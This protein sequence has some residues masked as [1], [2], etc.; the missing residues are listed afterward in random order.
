MLSLAKEKPPVFSKDIFAPSADCF[1]LLQD[2]TRLF[3]Q[4]VSEGYAE[5]VTRRWSPKLP[6]FLFTH[7]EM[8]QQT[9]AMVEEKDFLESSYLQLIAA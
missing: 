9:L 1:V 4:A 6:Q 5:N 7:P 8:C 3:C 2:A